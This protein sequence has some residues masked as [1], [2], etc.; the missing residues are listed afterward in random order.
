MPSDKTVYF[1]R[2]V[3]YQLMGNH[4]LAIKDFEQA[5]E[6]EPK[7]HEALY[8]VG[9]SRLAS[10]N[11]IQAEKDFQKALA[12]SDKPEIYEGLGLCFHMKQ[13]YE[14]AVSHFND[15]IT[16]DPTNVQFQRSLS[17]CYY[18][19]EKFEQSTICLEKARDLLTEDDSNVYYEL[20]LSLF[21]ER[22]YKKCLKI[23][24]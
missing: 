8:H 12:M 18:D 11:V 6:I 15:A 16:K 5:L 14:E 17:R 20:G 9:R 21:A 13:E 19:Q 1:E 4:E 3:V 2:G 22:H 10:K 24:K 7:Y 23:L